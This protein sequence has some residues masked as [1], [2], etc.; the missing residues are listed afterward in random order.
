MA[1][2]KAPQHGP[3]YNYDFGH[4]VYGHKQTRYVDTRKR[5]GMFTRPCPKCGH[6][7]TNTPHFTTFFSNDI[8]HS[9]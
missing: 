4:A 5:A 7:R 9:P 6:L 1:K 3:P 8:P 2:K